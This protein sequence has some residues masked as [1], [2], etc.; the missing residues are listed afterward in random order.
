MSKKK[1]EISRHNWS[2]IGPGSWN[3]TKWEIFDDLSVI[4]TDEYLDDENP[5][6]NP[7]KKDASN[8]T[9][10][11][12]DYDVLMDNIALAKTINKVVDAYDGEAWT[13]VEYDDDG[14]IKWMRET[15]YIYGLEPLEKI[16]NYLLAAN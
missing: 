4:K 2:E 16:S 7:N 11:Q 8:Y 14:S 13:F 12:E 3:N 1:L 15:G 5:R 10:K 6:Q 9:I